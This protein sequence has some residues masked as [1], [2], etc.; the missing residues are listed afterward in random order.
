VTAD[1]DPHP[2]LTLFFAIWAAVGPMVGIGLGYLLTSQQQRKQWLQDKR[3]EEYRELLS[4]LTTSY[5][6]LMHISEQ[7]E[8][9]QKIQ[10]EISLLGEKA[11]IEAYRV[12]RDRLII[13]E[14]IMSAE[15]LVEWDTAVTNYLKT[16]DTVKFANRFS[17][18]NATLVHMARK[19]PRKPSPLVRYR[20]WR[21]QRKMWKEAKEF[22]ETL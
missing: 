4:A 8:N 22:S 14:E 3:R 20:L 11:K 2:H 5:M 17:S 10:A 21:A 18:I 19:M 12:L 9:G 15:T 6:T 1:P 13:A 16:L 7:V